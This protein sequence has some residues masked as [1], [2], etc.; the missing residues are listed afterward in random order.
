MELRRLMKFLHNNF[1]RLM[2]L[3]KLQKKYLTKL[4]KLEVFIGEGSFKSST[5]KTISKI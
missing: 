4:T 2:K 5:A 3:K 1:R